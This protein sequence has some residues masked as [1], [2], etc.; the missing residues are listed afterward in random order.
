MVT[1]I[2]VSG[3][4]YSGATIIMKKNLRMAAVFAGT[5][6]GLISHLAAAEPPAVLGTYLKPDTM[7]KGEVIVVIP[8][9]EIG[10]YVAKVEEAAKREPE[11]F[12]EF[13][14]KAK[15]GV[16]LPYH[17]KMGLTKEDYEKYRSLWDQREA[18][19]VPDGN[20]VIR[21]EQPKEGE[22]M[23]RVTGVGS[24]VSLLRYNEG[25]DV[26]QSPNGL[27]QRIEEIAADA[28]SILGAWTGH[29]WRYMEENTLGRTKENFAIGKMADEKKGLLV[30]RLQE[31]SSTGRR[32]YDKSLVIRFALPVK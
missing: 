16:P 23:V 17:E 1:A 12:K 4:E 15:P 6:A 32:L 21:L 26:F 19:T 10:E 8:P 27:L 7:I 3:R 29:E 2:A 14:E 30:Y 20:V 9:R 13:S 24:P 5:L 28:Q 22:W 18:K 25:D 11:W 31:V